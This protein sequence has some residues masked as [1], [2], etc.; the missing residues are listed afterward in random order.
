MKKFLTTIYCCDFCTKHS[1]SAGA[2]AV[3]EKHCKANPTVKPL[4]LDCHWF[5]QTEEKKTFK[6]TDPEWD[7]EANWNGRRSYELNVNICDV[8][9]DSL[10]FRASRD[11]E[12]TI[13]SQSNWK[14]C[15]TVTQGCPYFID[16][17]D[18]I[19]KWGLDKDPTPEAV[20]AFKKEHSSE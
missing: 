6:N 7:P 19:I 11:K 12:H 8:T 20:L 10:Y 17:I 14:R 9:K 3:H 16:H 18:G 13:R 1:L 15:P 5:R 4:C 2:M